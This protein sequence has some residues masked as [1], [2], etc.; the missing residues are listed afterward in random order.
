MYKVTSSK[1]EDLLLDVL[2]LSRI[3]D[4]NLNATM[5]GNLRGLCDFPLRGRI[6]IEEPE[7]EEEKEPVKSHTGGWLIDDDIED[8]Y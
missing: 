6:I 1:R 4:K 3:I 8:D 5:R 2:P 7:V